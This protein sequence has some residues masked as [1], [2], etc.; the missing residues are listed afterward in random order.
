MLRNR[1]SKP[2]GTP[3][4]PLT[5]G[6]SRRPIATP[7]PARRPPITSTNRGA[8]DLP[9]PFRV[10]RIRCVTPAGLAK[11]ANRPD[12]AGPPSQGDSLP[13]DDHAAVQC[14]LRLGTGNSPE[15]DSR[16]ASGSD[17]CGCSRRCLANSIGP[18]CGQ[19]I[20]TTTFQQR[21]SGQIRFPRNGF[22][23][24]A[25]NCSAYSNE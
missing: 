1:P 18:G 14:V 15:R 25:R 24:R 23:K 13:L 8:P 17:L 22:S 21:Q 6:N 20:Q 3:E 4:I 12:E 16:I 10:I 9:D 7:R 11:S 2:R 19:L 5:L